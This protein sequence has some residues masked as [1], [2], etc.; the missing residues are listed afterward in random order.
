MKTIIA[1]VLASLLSSCGGDFSTLQVS[2]PG[3]QAGVVPT[4]PPAS[5][6]V[7]LQAMLVQVFSDPLFHPKPGLH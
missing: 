5:P 7:S 2:F 4:S 6:D 1:G 3:E